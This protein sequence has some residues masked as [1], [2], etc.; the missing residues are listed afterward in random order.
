MFPSVRVL[1]IAG[2]ARQP[3]AMTGPLAALRGLFCGHVSN[4]RA[5]A[6]PGPDDDPAR[7]RHERP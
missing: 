7:R 1:S 3:A 6:S 4:P 2:S 5:H